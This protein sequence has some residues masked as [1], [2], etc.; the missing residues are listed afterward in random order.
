MLVH[1]LEGA[2]PIDR[3]GSLVQ[4]I[5]H[6][7]YQRTADVRLWETDPAFYEALK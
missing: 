1:K 6:S 7:R 2:R 4:L 3:A 5:E